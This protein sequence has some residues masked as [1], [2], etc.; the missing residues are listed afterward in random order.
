MPDSNV[1]AVSHSILRHLGIATLAGV[2]L[3]GGIGGWAAATNLAGAVVA[4]GHFV[5]DTNV[6][7]VQHP[8]GGVVGEI[9][10]REGQRV[11]AGDIVMRLDA[12]QTRAN[13]AI[14]TK[15][16]D[17][18]AVRRARLR[19]ERDE[20]GVIAFPD[21][22]RSRAADPEIAQLMAGESRAVRT[23]PRRPPRPEGAASRARPSIRQG[24]AR[25]RGSGGSENSRHR[26]DPTRTD[27]RAR[28]LG[29]RAGA[30]PADDGAGTRSGKPRWR[31]WPAG[32][33]QAQSGGKISETRL[34]MIQID[35][36]LR[37]EVA[38]AACA[39]SRA[40]RR[41]MSNGR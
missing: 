18:F 36:D 27:R 10:V 25:P 20:A 12:T 41:N 8:T 15:R 13:L 38:A 33:S 6:K 2:V 34:Q 1:S 32:R 4:A 24:S 14:V 30:H 11:T 39:T 5:V 21:E 19:A 31:T 37:S 3:V 16:L 28:T 40:R 17:E 7:K 9:L 26:P 29:E 23:A 35:Q 22:I